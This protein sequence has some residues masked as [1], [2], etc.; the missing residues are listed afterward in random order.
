MKYQDITGMKFSHLT[1]KKYL[2]RSKWLCEC[3]CGRETTPYISELKKGISKSCGKCKF[4]VKSRGPNDLVGKRFGKLTVVRLAQPRKIPSGKTTYFWVCKCDCGNE[5]EVSSGHLTSGHTLSCGCLHQNMMDTIG[6]RTRTH[7]R[8]DKRLKTKSYKTWVY[9][10][11]RCYYEKDVDYKNYGA[12]GIKIAGIWLN[13]PAAFCEYV[14]ALDRYSEPGT[15]IDR[16]DSDGNYEPGNLRWATM[17]EQRR[18]T[19]RTH[20]VT[21]N[22]ETLCLLDWAKRYNISTNTIYRR[23]KECGMNEVEAITTPKQPRVKFVRG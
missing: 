9:I 12:R 4:S 21:I 10:K 3:D 14:E 17:A 19:S 1:A 18:N 20:L 23:I 15:T 11:R 8:C 13:D 22:G 16:I 2:G 5:T 6:E 7:G